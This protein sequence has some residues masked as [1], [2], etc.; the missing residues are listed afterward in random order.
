MD[1]EPVRRDTSR[2]N[3]PRG[4]R[5]RRHEL[6]LA[7]GGRLILHTDGSIDHVDEHGST[8]KSWTPDDPEWPGQAIRF[9]LRP[10]APTI[11]P[12]GR[13]VPGMKPPRW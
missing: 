8:A 5:F 12:Q 10:Q 11:T 1:D 7:D 4:G 9:G 2:T 3:A 6:G 13:R